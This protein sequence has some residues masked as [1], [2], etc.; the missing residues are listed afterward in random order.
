MKAPFKASSFQG[1]SG[2]VVYLE[3]AWNT[4]PEGNFDRQWVTC[5]FSMQ[6]DDAR[7]LAAQLVAAADAVDPK[8][9]EVQS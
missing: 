2:P 6:P 1:A 3:P 4:T 8:T 5:S 9:A 7:D